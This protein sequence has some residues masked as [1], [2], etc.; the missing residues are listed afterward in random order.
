MQIFDNKALQNQRPQAP[1]CSRRGSET[2]A[3]PGASGCPRPVP[4]PASSQE[5]GSPNP[6]SRSTLD[7]PLAEA[8]LTQGSRAHSAVEMDGPPP[9]MP[10]CH[11]LA[12]VSTARTQGRSPDAQPWP[13]G[14]PACWATYWHVFLWDRAASGDPVQSLWVIT[15]EPGG[16]GPS[17]PRFT[18]LESCLVAPAWPP[19]CQHELCPSHP[20]PPS[21]SPC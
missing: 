2:N 1:G 21:G 15:L 19:Q 13:M 18:S 6:W 3:Q 14:E 20:C 8:S 17:S 9:H 16:H 12:Y 5:L 7:Q 4:A 10:P 11:C